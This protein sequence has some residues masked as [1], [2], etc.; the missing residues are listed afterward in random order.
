MFTRLLNRVLKPVPRF[1][2]FP[3]R[4]SS[5]VTHCSVSPL[6]ATWPY[7]GLGWRA[8]RFRHRRPRIRRTSA[9]T[10]RILSI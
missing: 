9:G 6:S 5:S 4:D 8:F 7:S 1:A 10:Y 3:K 2:A